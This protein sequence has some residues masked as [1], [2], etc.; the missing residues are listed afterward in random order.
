[1]FQGGGSEADYNLV[2]GAEPVLLC[3]KN[4]GIFGIESF[5]CFVLMNGSQM[6]EFGQERGNTG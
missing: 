6:V 3:S 2:P 5:Y 4:W 1:M